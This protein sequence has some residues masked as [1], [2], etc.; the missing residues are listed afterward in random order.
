[1]A[2][3]GKNTAINNKNPPFR[4]VFGENNKKKINNKQLEKKLTSLLTFFLKIHDG[5]H[6]IHFIWPNGLPL[7]LD[8]PV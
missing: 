5:K 6:R 7:Y 8:I 4:N 1:M 2:E 3:H